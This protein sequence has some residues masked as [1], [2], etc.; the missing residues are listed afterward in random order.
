[1]AVVIRLQGLPIVAGTMDIRHFFSGLTIPDGGVHIVGGDHGEA[2]IVF[3]TDEDARL[4]MMRTGGAI[5]GSKVSL[6]LSSKTEM[7]NMI[8]LSRRRFESG[9]PETPAAGTRPPAAAPPT[10]APSA[11]P[12]AAQFNAPAAAAQFNTP[13]AAAQFA[14]PTAAAQFATPNPAAQFATPTAAAQFATPAA[15]AQFATPT[16]AATQDAKAPPNMGP[17]FPSYSSAPTLTTALASLTP[18]LAALPNMAALPPMPS[19]PSLPP[20]AVPPVPPMSHLPHM[21]LPP[22]NPSLPPPLATPNP[23]LFNP[24]TPLTPLGL[25][26]M[27]AVSAAP[28]VAAAVSNP[29]DLI[30]SLQNLPYACTEP[31]V[32]DFFR[33]LSVEAVRFVRDSQGRTTGRAL[34][35]FFTPQDSFEALKRGGGTVGQRFV[36]VGPASE[37]QWNSVAEKEAEIQERGRHSSMSAE[38]RGRSRSPHRHDLCVYLKGLP[39]EVD[40]NQVKEFFKNLQMDEDSLYIAYGPNGKATGEGFLEF[41]TEADYKAALAAHMQ[42]MGARFIQVHPISRKGMMDKIEQIRRRE[43]EAKAL[44]AQRAPKTCLHI[45]NIPYNVSRKDVRAFLDG[46]A[47]YD[48]TLKV[49]TDAHGNGLGQAVVQLHSEEDA[50]K[51]ERLHRQKL[52]GRDAFVHLVTFD[53]MKEV[54]RNPPPQNKRGQRAA[55]SQATPASHLAPPPAHMAPPPAHFGP[56]NDD[57]SFIRNPSPF[58]PPFSAPGNGLAPPPIPPLGPGLGGLGPELGVPPPLVPGLPAPV[59]DPPGF[60]PGGAGPP[61]GHDLPGMVPFDRKTP[62][63]SNGTPRPLGGSPPPAFPPGPDSALHGAP[64]PANGGGPTVVKLQNMP[65][66]VSADE[67]LDFLY[68]YAVVPGSVCLQ[69]NDK[70]LPSGEAL[71]AFQSPEE[72]TAAVAD[73]NER[74]IGSR[75]VKMS[76]G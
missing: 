75:K 68:G 35:R 63:R 19:L 27:K 24:L 66:T 54:E 45:T 64:P 13:S 26:H 53:Y 58:A 21:T 29:D 18:P 65:F 61:F 37:R 44:D 31:E 1:M 39:Y 7:Q 4:G 17:S 60:R 38:H 52:N 62:T 32:R 43:S 76:L 5:K 15:A 36:E 41:K 73:L 11:P 69:F 34:A 14:T 42:Y 33:G 67:I 57:F 49:L 8:E 22:F 74:P 25:Q 56:I 72:A 23:L 2:F 70:G 51:A 16:A 9:P 55:L 20:P 28:P 30:L 3:A 50:R 10:A 71:V 46:L 59:L 40:K 6:L 48:D 12:R 47:M